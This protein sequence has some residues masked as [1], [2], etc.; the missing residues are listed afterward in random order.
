MKPVSA[1][2]RPKSPAHKHFG[3]CVLSPDSGNIKAAL[4]R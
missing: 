3:A 1:S 4:L 2:I